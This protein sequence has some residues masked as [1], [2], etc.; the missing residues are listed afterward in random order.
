MVKEIKSV[1]DEY[2]PIGNPES[3]VFHRPRR[4]PENFLKWSNT[5]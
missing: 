4:M 5:T 3:P 2:T 1:A